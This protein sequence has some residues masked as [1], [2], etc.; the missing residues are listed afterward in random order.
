[1]NRDQ[2][3]D[4]LLTMLPEDDIDRAMRWVDEYTSTLRGQVGTAYWD[5]EQVAEFIGA[6]STAA[7]R[8]T[9]SRWGIEAAEYA[10]TGSGRS[11]A[12]YPAVAVR[13]AYLNKTLKETLR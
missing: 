12:L 9:L 3:R 13:Q 11:K 1:M 7:A 8:S 6:S 4:R 5:A 10:R 2:L